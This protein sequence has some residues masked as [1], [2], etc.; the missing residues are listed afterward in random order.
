MNTLSWLLYFAEV[1]TN[2]ANFGTFLM[3]ASGV[4][5]A[6]LSLINL[7]VPDHEK[8][9]NFM[10]LVPSYS[11]V[12]AVVFALGCT[13]IVF[14]SQD[15]VYLIIASESAEMV[16]TSE[17]GK[18]MMGDIQEII[19]LKLNSIAESATSQISNGNK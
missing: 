2:I 15:T 4:S 14:P 19:S 1:S 5:F 6:L 3:I 12:A 11:K 17:G 13:S 9:P 7:I 10:R 16:V 8:S 18:Q